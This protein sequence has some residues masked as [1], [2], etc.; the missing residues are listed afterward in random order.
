MLPAQYPSLDPFG[1]SLDSHSKD[2]LLL[3]SPSQCWEKGNGKPLSADQDAPQISS[4]I[5][6]HH[7][8]LRTPM[9]NKYCH[10]RRAHL[11]RRICHHLPPVQ[12][13]WEA[14]RESHRGGYPG[15]VQNSKVNHRTSSVALTRRLRA[16]HTSRP[17][18]VLTILLRARFERARHRSDSEP[19]AKPHPFSTHLFNLQDIQRFNRPF[20]QQV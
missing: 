7:I 16:V 15:A 2:P 5:T 6:I 4:W 17:K 20:P 13:Y 18:P 8:T 1:S 11:Q 10:R 9:R 19:L 14:P 3:L 12:A